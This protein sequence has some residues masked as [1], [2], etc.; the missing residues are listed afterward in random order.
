MMP[1]NLFEV[2]A[3]LN[4]DKQNNIHRGMV[5]T[6][7]ET[8]PDDHYIVEFSNN[9]GETIALSTCNGNDL[10]TLEHA[11]VSSVSNF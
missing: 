7:V 2:V 1:H 4:D 5:G 11:T 8:L 9:D 10:L 6:V 3:I